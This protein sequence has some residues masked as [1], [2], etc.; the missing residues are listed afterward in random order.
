MRSAT[1]SPRGGRDEVLQRLRAVVDSIPP[2]RVATYGQVAREAGLPRHARH[3]GSALRSLPPGSALPWHRVL[4]A[5]GA[6]SERPCEGFTRQRSLL[7]A[8]GVVFDRHGRVDLERFGCRF[9]GDPDR[10]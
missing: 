9:S 8:E 2:G 3:V 5:R 6:I 10:G 4:N 7:E 1:R